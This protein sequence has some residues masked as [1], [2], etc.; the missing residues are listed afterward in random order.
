MPCK[1]KIPE[2]GYF[3]ENAPFRRKSVIIGIFRPKMPYLRRIFHNLGNQ[4]ENSPSTA[5]IPTFGHV[6]RK[7]SIYGE[8]PEISVFL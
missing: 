6:G 3:G 2:V 7:C 8:T 5:K 1:V 4:I